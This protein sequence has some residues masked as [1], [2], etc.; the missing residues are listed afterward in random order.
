MMRCGVD[1]FLESEEYELEDFIN[2]IDGRLEMLWI[3]D[4][5]DMNLWTLRI[6]YNI[7]Y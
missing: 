7:E 4:F 2:D 3:Y 1:C 5:H 6:E